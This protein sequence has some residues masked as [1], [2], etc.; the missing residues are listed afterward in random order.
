MRDSESSRRSSSPHGDGGPLFR[1][2]EPP[3]RPHVWDVAALVHAVADA[4][5]ARF[6]AVAVRGELSGYGRAP[7]G[8]CYFTLK[9][10]EGTAALRCAMF[11]RAAAL[12]DFAPE[13]GDLVEVR[14][15]LAVYE[16]R[17]ELQF[18]V[19]SMRH[20][21]AGTLY[22]RFL[23][24]K[25]QLEA[26]GLFDARRK[27]P[28]S[29]H[30]RGIALVTSLAAAA[31]HDVVSA[32]QRRAPHVPIVICPSPVQGGEAPALLA[33]AIAAA[34]CCDRIDTLLV[35]R[36]G[37][38]LEDLWPFNEAA[39]VRAIAAST[40]P[41]IV[42]VGHETD[43]TLADFAADLR[44]PTPT[45]AAELAALPREDALA[46]LH[47]RDARLK[48]SIAQRLDAQAQ[49]LDRLA[50]RL[51]RPAQAL[52]PL[53]QRLALLEARLRS[54]PQTHLGRQR[55]R[56]EA[57][58]TRLS[59]ALQQEGE[60]RRRHALVLAARLQALDPRRVLARGYA[61]LSDESGRALGSVRQVE[62]GAVLQAQLVD[63]RVQ[64]RVSAIEPDEPLA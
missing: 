42:G 36:G 10:A 6:G 21:G 1:A 37:G 4:L 48:R 22:E 8:H 30:P 31:L 61:W 40:L 45:A 39:V 28:I 19:E 59:Q 60:R 58:T 7:S 24:L 14:G 2:A 44:A 12:L 16:P 50:L 18:V 17:G 38:S 54:V 53:R 13:E 63:G 33:R 47:G 35:C 26:E 20:A 5:G 62:A 52:A 34:G 51:A 9:D 25:V 32:L 23:R 46:E 49:R 43:V 55:Q 57:L 3:A 64:A 27:R 11:R 15:R 29:L 56:G 41:V